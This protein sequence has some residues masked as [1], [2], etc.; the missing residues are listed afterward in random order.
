MYMHTYI[1]I[2]TYFMSK[3]HYISTPVRSFLSIHWHITKTKE[4]G[5][6]L[7]F[8]V[9]CMF[10]FLTLKFQIPQIYN[11]IIIISS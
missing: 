5:K 9:L 1:H 3:I 2:Y 8:L 7:V 6:K 10:F 11:Y 4:S